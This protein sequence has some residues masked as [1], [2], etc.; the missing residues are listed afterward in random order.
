[1]RLA[2]SIFTGA[3]SKAGQASHL[4]QAKGNFPF[5]GPLFQC[6]IVFRIK[7]REQYPTPEQDFPLPGGEGR[8]EEEG[9]LILPNAPTLRF[10]VTIRLKKTATTSDLIPVGKST[11]SY[12][13]PKHTPA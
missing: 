5:Y 9:S 7:T 10:T 8:G 3:H 1:M 11:S 6:P 13:N 4:P 2:S 12:F